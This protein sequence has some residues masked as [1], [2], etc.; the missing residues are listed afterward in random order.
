MKQSYFDPYI[1]LIYGTAISL[2]FCG[3]IPMLISS[4]NPKKWVICAVLLLGSITVYKAIFN[5]RVLAFSFLATALISYFLGHLYV[6][7]DAF[8]LLVIIIFL[9]IGWVFLFGK[10]VQDEISK[11][12]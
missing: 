7:L 6:R 2:F 9:P 5:N 11:L 8:A 4:D 10:K 3:T 1:R 12:V